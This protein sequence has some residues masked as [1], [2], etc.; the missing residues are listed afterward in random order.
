MTRRLLA[1]ISALL[2]LASPVIAQAQSRPL[3][4]VGF[5]TDFDLKD[6]AVAICKAVMD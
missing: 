3:R 2:L 6:D 4:V 1:L 5:M